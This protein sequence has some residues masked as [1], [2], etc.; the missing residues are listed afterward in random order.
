MTLEQIDQL[1]ADWRKKL[2]PVGQNLMDLHGLPTYQWL[3]GAPGFPKVQL[4]GITQARV[5]PALE[6]MNDL[7]QHFDLLLNTVN[8]ATELR[9][10]V[11]WF[12]VSEGKAKEAQAA[13]DQVY[14]DLP[15]ELAPKLALGLAAEQAV[16]FDLAIKMYDLVS[17][18]SNLFTRSRVEVARTLIN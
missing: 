1:L 3:S 9:K 15:G 13:F 10:Q 12:L 16:N 17:Q 11:S 18:T 14:F 7:F 2:D 4:M 5:T 6:A 8:K